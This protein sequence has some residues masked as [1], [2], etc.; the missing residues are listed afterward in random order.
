[1]NDQKRF[2]GI[3]MSKRSFEVA[4]VNNADPRILRKSI[5]QLKRIGKS[6]F[7]R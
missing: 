3:D 1:M 7:L 5:S 6:L 2:I 4:I